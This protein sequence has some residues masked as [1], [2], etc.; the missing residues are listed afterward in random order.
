MLTPSGKIL[1]TDTEENTTQHAMELEAVISSLTYIQSA[2]QNV[3]AIILY[4]DSE[5]VLNLLKRRNR[6]L[7]NNF[8]T[9]NGKEIKNRRLIVQFYEFLENYPVEMVKVKGHSRKGT[10]QITDY[11]REVDKLSRKLVREKIQN[12]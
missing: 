10:S 3:S 6:L 7:E 9:K 11:H 5:Y 4:T 2:F 1:L 8:K 12:R